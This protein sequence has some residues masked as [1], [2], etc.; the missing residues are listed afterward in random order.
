MLNLGPLD[1]NLSR[2]DLQEPAVSPDLHA[3]MSDLSTFFFF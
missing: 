1:F 2:N 3:N